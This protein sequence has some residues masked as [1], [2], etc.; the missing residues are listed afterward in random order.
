MWNNNY[1]KSLVVLRT[2][3]LYVMGSSI[4][5]FVSTITV[6]QGEQEL[7]NAA[8]EGEYRNALKSASMDGLDLLAARGGFAGLSGEA[9]T[10]VGRMGATAGE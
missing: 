1:H 2:A 6:L 4:G 8:F 7:Y 3:A 10:V 9:V 5:A